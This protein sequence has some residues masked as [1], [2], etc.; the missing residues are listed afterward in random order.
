MY[1][2]NEFDCPYSAFQPLG[3][4]HN[5]FSR[6]MRLYKK[7]A[8]NPPDPN[9]GYIANAQATKEVADIQRQTATDYLNFSKQQYEEIKPQLQAITDQQV[10]IADANEKRASEYSDYEKATYRPLEKS[11]VDEANNYNTEANTQKLASKAAADVNIG[12]SNAR[13]QNTRA[14]ASMGINPNSGRFAALNNQL[15]MQQGADAAGAQTNARQNAENLGYARKLDAA[16][17]GRGLASNASTA[18]G[19]SINSGNSAGEN[20]KSAANYMGGAYGQASGMYGQAGS[21]YGIAGQQY[22]NM[23][24]Q[25]M[26]AYQAKQQNS[27][28]IMGGIG[29]IVGRVGASYLTGGIMKADGGPIYRAGGGAIRG[30]GGPVD[31]KIPA[32]LSDGEYVLPADTVK[33]IGVKKL[34]KVVKKT[35]TPAAEQRRKALKGKK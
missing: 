3:G 16:G 19:I 8:G 15:A 2:V 21:T 35:H 12:Y 27:A 11:I 1:T 5:P 17:L 18:Y 26:Q 28:S 22:G 4:K 34:D 29:N 9:P 24:N 13:D 30:P 25:Q 31:D 23:Y 20:S 33:K 14:M 6:G 10:R 32:M 7:D